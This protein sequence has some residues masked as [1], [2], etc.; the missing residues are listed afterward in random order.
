DGYRA[1]E[2]TKYHSDVDAFVNTF[3][4]TAP[5]NDL[6]CALNVHRVDV[7]STDSGAD[8]PATC[9]D[10]STGSGAAPKTYFD[11]TFCSGG[12]IRRLLLCD[13]GSAKNVATTQVPEVHIALVMV[14]T[15]EY[16][17]SGGAVAIFSTNASS[18][19]IAMHEMG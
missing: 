7:V 14:N 11:S 4:S 5:Y 18:T 19:E 13:S 1:S 17:G 15:N 6:W 16:G 2:L 9:A 8:D 12:N 10:G 3:R